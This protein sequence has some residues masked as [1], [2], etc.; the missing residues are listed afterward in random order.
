MNHRWESDGRHETG[1]ARLRC[2]RCGMLASWPGASSPC[3]GRAASGLELAEAREL[4]ATARRALRRYQRELVRER[5]W[6]LLEARACLSRYRSE[7]D[8]RGGAV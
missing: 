1:E 4:L 2:A 7:L 3:P 8:Q 5:R 6:N